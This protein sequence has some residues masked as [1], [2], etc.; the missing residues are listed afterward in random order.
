MKRLILA[1]YLKE[2]VCNKNQSYVKREK[3]TLN[4]AFIFIRLF[5]LRYKEVPRAQDDG[6]FKCIPWSTKPIYYHKNMNWWWRNCFIVL[7][8]FSDRW[9]A[10][11]VSVRSSA[12]N[13]AVTLQMAEDD[14]LIKIPE[15]IGKWFFIS[16]YSKYLE[17]ENIVRWGVKTLERTNQREI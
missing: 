17:T 3:N 4:K 14:F 10:L 9:D 7:N 2:F 1:Q 6:T 5:P 15:E 13:R 16:S 12:T 8:S 11:V